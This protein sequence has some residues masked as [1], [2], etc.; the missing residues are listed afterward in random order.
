MKLSKSV[1]KT[2]VI[3]DDEMKNKYVV[4][5]DWDKSKRKALIL[6][7]SASLTDEKMYSIRRQCM[8]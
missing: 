1:I 4:K 7:K 8:S 5:K 3:Y 6:M 2:K